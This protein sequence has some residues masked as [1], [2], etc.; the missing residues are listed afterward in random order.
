[1]STIDIALLGDIIL[2]V[3]CPDHWLSGIA[4]LTR[5]VDVTIAHL[6]VP[7]TRRGVEMQG[8]VPAPGADPDHLAAL[9]RAGITAVSL[10]GNHVADCGAI[11]IEDTIAELDRL[12]IAHAGAGADLHAARM[13]AIIAAGDRRVVLLSFNCVGPEIGWATEDRA[14][15]AY[16]RVAA[17]DGG[18]TRP[19]ASLDRIDPVSL[20]EMTAAIRAEVRPDTLVVVA[21]HKGVT[22]SPAT[23]APYERPLA[24]AAIEAGADVIAGHHAHIA[25]GIEYHRGK[26][27]FHGLGNG[28][29]VTNALSPAQDHPARREWAERRKILFGFAP[30]PAYTLAPFHPEARNGMIGRLRWHADGRIDSGLTPLW[31]EAPGRPVLA[32]GER[33]DAVARY[34]DSVGRR[35]GLPALDWSQLL[36]FCQ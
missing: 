1:M 13:P 12:G 24:Q 27:I 11:G 4:P 15:A 28:V 35:V 18:E 32:C 20:A 21:L 36:M 31:F 33:A 8:D 16:V 22:H 9:A 3:P 29:V 19:Q 5:A 30:D 14:G 7:H 2:D 17:T 23:L 6:E 25:Q 34:I 10:A 26:P